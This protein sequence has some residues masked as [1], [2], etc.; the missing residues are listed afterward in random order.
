MSELLNHTPQFSPDDAEE[1]SRNYYG[2]NSKAEAL[3]SERDQ[4]FKLTDDKGREYVLKISNSLEEY[5]LLEMQNQAMRYLNQNVYPDVCPAPVVSVD[6]KFINTLTDRKGISHYVRLLNFIPGQF[7]S[8]IAPLED[9]DLFDIG[10]L[11][12]SIDNALFSFQHLSSYR[13]FYWDLK[14]FPEVNQY[15]PLLV[16]SERRKIAEHFLNRYNVYVRPRL[17]ELR[18]SIIHNDGNDNNILRR[19]GVK[20]E[21]AFSIIDFGDMVHTHTV[22]EL[23]IVTAYLI[24]GSEAPLDTASKI[25]KGYNNRLPLKDAEL[26][27][28]LNLIAARLTMS[29]CISAYQY[30]INPENEYL[31]ISEKPAWDALEKLIAVDPS[32]ALASFR[33]ACGLK[34]NAPYSDTGTLLEKREKLLGPNLSL[35]YKKPLHIVRGYGQYLFDANGR[36]YLDCVNNVCHVGHCHPKVNDAAV[37]QISMLNTNTRYLHENILEYAEKLTSKFPDPLN[38]CYF[39][40]S[41]SEA[42]ELALRLAK[43]FTGREDMIVVDHAY[44]GNTSSTIDISPYKF[45]GPGGKSIP[46]NVHKVNIPDV[47]RNPGNVGLNN[48]G[49]EYALEVN[50]LLKE[51][52]GK[53]IHPAGFIAESA[54][55]VAG[56]IFFPEGYLSNVYKY[57]HDA[58]GVCIADEVQIGFGRVGSH[59]WGFELQGVVPDIV[60]LGKPIGN[61]H[62]IGAVVTT[63]EIAEAFDNGMEYFNTFGGNPVSCAIGLEVLNVI[64]EENLQNNAK[65]VGVYLLDKLNLLKNKHDLIGD[66]RGKGLFIGIELVK[67]Q[68]A[69]IPAAG[70]A[71]KVVDYMKDNFVL[72]STDGPY[73]NVIKFKPPMIFNKDNADELVSKLDELL[74]NKL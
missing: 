46:E 3:Q 13:N 6:S 31:K 11:Y 67:D 7:I 39:V 52:E 70:E 54:A 15:L 49:R 44:H 74:R 66:V 4:N 69:K 45:D 57:I 14:N 72:L 47:Y 58:G 23:A 65:D 37:R 29:V 19:T 73:H 2:L 55:G 10:S 50:H 24:F 22:N 38:V 1:I 34:Y 26:D 12:G 53:R 32:D 25:L 43:N 64:E 62:P 5:S 71:S 8:E 16:D 9:D 28:L 21:E 63:S 40:C 20:N 17:H 48:A 35:S 68:S 27:V 60:T 30:S 36:A 42:N 59:F 51:L 33:D 61:G 18:S 56:Q 41:G